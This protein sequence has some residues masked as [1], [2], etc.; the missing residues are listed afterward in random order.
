M[1]EFNFTGFISFEAAYA[2]PTATATAKIGELREDEM[3]GRWRYCKAGAA[4]TNPLL[5]L[6]CYAQPADNT[7]SATAI[8]SMTLIVTDATCTADQYANGTILIGAAAAYRRFYHVRSNT[9]SDG[10][11]T[12][13]TLYHPIRYAIAGT[14]WATIVPSPYSDVRHISAGAGLMSVVCMALQTVTS[15]YY[16]W[17]K[18]RGP[19]YGIVS[20]TVP[21]AASNDR[22][23]VFQGTDGA[24]IMADEAWNAGNSQQYAGYLLPRTGSTYGGGDQTFM[25]Q[26]E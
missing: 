14:E 11:Y 23:I 12:T 21:G 18:T 6:G 2:A 20:S 8:G 19:A 25:L 26:L 5:G 15:G 17:G 10:T 13:L 22:A 9:A 3:G 7:P 16:F 1:S 24:L 4:I